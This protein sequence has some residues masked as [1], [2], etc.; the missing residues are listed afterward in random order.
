VLAIAAPK[1]WRPPAWPDTQDL[2][3]VLGFE[4][5]LAKSS[6]AKKAWNG[7]LRLMNLLQFLPYFYVGCAESV[8]PAPA[9]R[10]LGSLEPDAWADIADIVLSDIAPLVQELRQSGVPTP[11]A[12]YE[13]AGSDGAVYGTF[14]IAWPDRKV[15]V[16]IDEALASSFP[17]W[18]VVVFKRD[19]SPLEAILECLR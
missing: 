19:A 6:E 15:G 10:T 5:R 11:E 12:L 14:E 4:H 9:I 2:T 17:G 7:A 13:A 1:T 18:T 16:V 8:E 3:V